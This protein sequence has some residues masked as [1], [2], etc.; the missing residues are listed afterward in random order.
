VLDLPEVFAQ[1]LIRFLDEPL[2][3]RTSFDEA[4]RG[5]ICSHALIASSR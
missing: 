2:F 5:V 4:L 3:H 1:V